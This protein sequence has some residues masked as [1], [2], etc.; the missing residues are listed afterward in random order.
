MQGKNCQEVPSTT[1]CKTSQMTYHME[2]YLGLMHG[3]MQFC[4]ARN[5]LNIYFKSKFNE[6]FICDIYMFWLRL[7][8][9]G[10][11]IS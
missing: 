6:T 5:K 4:E 7:L 10:S 1:V 8:K 3:K 2:D 9:L 11:K